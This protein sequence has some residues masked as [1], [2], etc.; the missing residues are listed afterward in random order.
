M[1]TPTR[2]CHCTEPATTRVRPE[3]VD[4]IQTDMATGIDRIKVEI[5]QF[6][7]SFM[8][9]PNHLQFPLSQLSAQM[10][11]LS[12]LEDTLSILKTSIA[13]MFGSRRISRPKH[14]SWLIRHV[15]EMLSTQFDDISLCHVFHIPVRT[16]FLQVY[17]NERIMINGRKAVYLCC[18]ELN[19]ITDENCEPLVFELFRCG[20]GLH[21][22]NG[23][24][25]K[26]L[27]QDVLN[28][29]IHKMQ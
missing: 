11:I 1:E 13:T 19:S 16:G 28:E 8:T 26:L 22:P 15:A 10:V 17:L 3:V 29:V 14:S 2:G 27:I 9:I 5:C 4:L 6:V 20:A 24:Y 18:K 23:D 7:G 25:I 21:D 12:I